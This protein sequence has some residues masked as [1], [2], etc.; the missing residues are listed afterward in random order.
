MGK[1]IET[2]LLFK[3]TSHSL[4][5]MKVTVT[6]RCKNT[7]ETKHVYELTNFKTSLREK[8]KNSSFFHIGKK[9]TVFET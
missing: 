7:P 5:Q 9:N 2:F 8:S 4:I 3:S 1:I 6:L